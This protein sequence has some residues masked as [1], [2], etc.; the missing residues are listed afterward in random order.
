MSASKT[1]NPA[2]ED[3]RLK[4]RS[5]SGLFVAVSP[6]ATDDTPAEPALLSMPERI[7]Q[8]EWERDQLRAQLAERDDRLQAIQEIGVALSSAMSRD[9]VLAL[10]VDKTTYLMRAER[11]TVFLLDEDK[12]E[13]WSTVAQGSKLRE[14]RL[15][16]GEGIAGWVAKTGKSLNIKDAYRDDRFN[17]SIDAITGFQTH[18]CLCQPI[19]NRE[20][21]ILGVLQV[22]NKREDYFTIEDENL[23][24]M[25]ASQ[26]G[27]AIEN[28]TLFYSVIGK[29]V[30]LEE[31]KERLEQKIRE[32]DLLY[33]IEREA[34]QAASLDALVYSIGER[35]V[36]ALETEAA[37]LLLSSE[38]GEALFLTRRLGRGRGFDHQRFEHPI[39]SSLARRVLA[40][41]QALI[42]DDR[43]SAELRDPALDKLGVRVRSAVA[44]PL[45]AND[46][47]LGVLEVVNKTGFVEGI[48]HRR[49]EHADLKLLTVI[50]SQ[51]S[52]AVTNHLYRERQEKA[53]RLSAIGQ[54]VSS[55]LHDLRTPISI[56]SGYV[57]LMVRQD[58]SSLR[59][60]YAEAVLK[61][62]ETLN[63]MAREILAFVRGD[64]TVL[65]RRVLMN[66]FIDEARQMLQNELMGHDIELHIDARYKGPA[67]FDEVKLKRVFANLGRNAAEAMPDGGRLEVRIEKSE[68]GAEGTAQA[69]NRQELEG[70]GQVPNRQELEGAGQVPKRQ[71]VEGAGQ[72]PKR[73]E[74][75]FSFRDTGRGIP[76]EIQP[77]LFQSF[78]TQG[79]KNGTGLGL[80]IVKK[81][82]DE[83]HGWITYTS[84]EN[85][86]T[87][88]RFGL[89]FE[90]ENS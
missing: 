31:Y 55:L 28:S 87:E 74:L 22:L 67:R 69:P 36:D 45:Q 44:V 46:Q 5:E 76:K 77:Q 37:L 30:E 17:Q 41:G 20:R 72:V 65:I 57:Q 25:I 90:P 47:L 84:A 42:A 1:N 61:Q 85:E 48:G 2:T 13:L 33:E 88:F 82:I 38:S 18:S 51:V 27:V 56:I 70:A 24:S 81:I 52:S 50:G 14:I 89:P 49:F 4:P 3:S 64:S 62:F 71:E 78:V 39:E 6:L 68:Q 54:M 59:A 35:C 32:I 11:S 8:L 73:Q 19:R 80:A 15:R 60:E 7:D 86:G 43:N 40:S 21:R 63:S 29:N 9:A 12:Q 79:K 53:Q 66:R 26:A 16:V 58:N 83:H 23:L 34:S 75:L 10:I